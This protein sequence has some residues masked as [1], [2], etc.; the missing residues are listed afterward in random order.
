MGSI[1]DNIR[2]ILEEIPGG[3]TLA[4]AAKSRSPAEVE[5]AIAAGVSV[6]GQ[7]YLQEAGS[8]RPLVRAPA[9]WHF[10]GHL[11]RRKVRA[12]LELF[13]MIETLDSLKLAREIDRRAAELGRAMAVLIEVNSGREPQKHGVFPEDAPALLEEVAELPHLRVEGLMTMGPLT[14]DP[15]EARPYFVE[16]RRLFERLGERLPGRARM[17]VL[18]MGMSNSYPVAV[19]EG[20]TLIR[21]GTAIFGPRPA[22]V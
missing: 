22:A 7:N 10:I 1:A 20:A 14:G 15:E 3:V 4:A 18:S 13:D 6:I 5:E 11:Q 21:V 9:R 12:A 8:V 17:E 16:T 2:R 19:Q